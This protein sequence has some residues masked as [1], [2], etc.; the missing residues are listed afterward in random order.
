MFQRILWAGLVFT[1]VIQL[2]C[3]KPVVSEQTPSEVLQQRAQSYWTQI[4]NAD[5][6][7]LYNDYLSEETREWM[8]Y[9]SYVAKI[10]R[11]PYKNLRVEKVA[12]ARD[13]LSA[14]VQVRF[15]V[16]YMQNELKGM[17]LK[18]SWQWEAGK[19][20]LV[21]DQRSTPFDD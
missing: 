8:Y 17:I 10:A 5:Y 21:L 16:S 14:I 2:G 9:K 3:V 11:L 12:I 7:N 13:G 1:I 19:W 6:E 18:Q 15:D 4:E 20:V